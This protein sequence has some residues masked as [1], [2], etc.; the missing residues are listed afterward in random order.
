MS[1][2]ISS[3]FY[4]H[5]VREYATVE[6]FREVN[7]YEEYYAAAN[8]IQDRHID[9][10]DSNVYQESISDDGFEAIVTILFEDEAACEAYHAEMES[11]YDFSAKMP[12]H[13]DK[14]ME[15]NDTIHL[16]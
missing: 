5:I 4:P 3:V 9:R 7:G 1:I 8:L 6:E 11:I 14:H 2:K 15:N 10:S 16:F 12:L 13:I